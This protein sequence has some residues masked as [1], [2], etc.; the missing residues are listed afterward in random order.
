MFIYITTYLLPMKLRC[1]RCKWQWDYKG[2][3]EYYVTCPHCYSKVRI[4][5][6]GGKDE[7]S[8]EKTKDKR[9]KRDSNE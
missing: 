7:I 8:N 3:G 4:K 2:K 5:K 6:L 9:A 1:K